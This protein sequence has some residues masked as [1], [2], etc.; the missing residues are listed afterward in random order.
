MRLAA[1]VA[2]VLLQLPD[3]APLLQL[4]HLD[5]RGEQLEVVA[6]VAGELLERERVLGEAGA[7][8]ADPGAEEV[9]PEPVVEPDASRHLDSTSAPV[10]SQ[11]FAISLMKLMRVI[12]NAFEASLT[13][14]AEATSMR[15]TGASMPSCSAATASPSASSNAPIDDAVGL[16]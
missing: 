12:R 8:E 9:R 14:S 1:Q 13:I 7:A 3:H 2:E 10:A 4:V 16:P 15:T 11:T 5:H 6:R